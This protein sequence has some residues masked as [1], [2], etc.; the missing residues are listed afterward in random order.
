MLHVAETR[1]T[2]GL[3]ALCDRKSNRGNAS[4]TK[5]AKASGGMGLRGMGMRSSLSSLWNQG[6]VRY[7]LVVLIEIT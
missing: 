6:N 4:F 5:M 2:D 7:K 1:L 3:N